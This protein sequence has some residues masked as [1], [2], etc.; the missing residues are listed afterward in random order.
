MGGTCLAF[1]RQPPGVAMD[2]DNENPKVSVIIPCYNGEKFIREAVESV[3]DQTYQNFEI[4]IVDDGSTDN[5]KATIELYLTDGRIKFIQH[6]R[7]RGIPAARNTGIKASTGHFIAFLDQDDIWYPEKLE[8]SLCAFDKG[9]ESLGVVFSDVNIEERDGSVTRR[10]HRKYDSVKL[11]RKGFIRTLFMGNFI[12]TSSVVTR[13]I[14][15]NKLGLLDERLYGGDDF[16]FWLRVA[17][18]FDFRYLSEVLLKIRRHSDNAS[19]KAVYTMIDQSMSIIVPKAIQRYP[20]LAS[21]K[22]RKTSSLYYSFGAYLI[23]DG[24][25]AKARKFFIKAIRE[26]SLNWKAWVRLL[27]SAIAAC[28][29]QR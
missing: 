4:I 18:T 25:A 13:K 20:F 19:S 14:C 29:K 6:G 28:P 16:D 8:K 7:N 11:G 1:V 10:T 5:S 17:G 12:P 23:R 21:L 22:G 15:F 9:A 27:L 24:E 26:R 3:L 2:T